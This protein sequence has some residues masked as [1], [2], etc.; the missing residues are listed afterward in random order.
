MG[1]LGK[2]VVNQISEKGGGGVNKRQLR[3]KII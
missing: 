1:R 2:K 3:A